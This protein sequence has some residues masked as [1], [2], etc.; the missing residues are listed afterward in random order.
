MAVLHFSFSWAFALTALPLVL[1]VLARREEQTIRRKFALLGQIQTLSNMLVFFSPQRRFLR[2]LLGALCVFF[3]ILALAGPRAGSE[4]EMRPRQGLDVVFAI[5]VSKSMR[6]QDVRPDRLARAQ[7]EIASFLEQIGENRVG[8]VAF[9]GTAFVQCPLTTDMEAVRTFLQALSPEQM[10]QGGTALAG[11]IETAI[12]LFEAQ[13][14]VQDEDRRT[15]R[16][17]VVIT[18]G[19]DH[20]GRT[21]ELENPQD[22]RH[23]DGGHRAWL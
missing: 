12:R 6:A 13:A 23:H 4:T 19:E 7:F 2:R 21:E 22:G 1:F 10:P 14:A 16:I 17:L 3:T 15:G 8:L 11:G 5:D 20:E 9:A 18:D